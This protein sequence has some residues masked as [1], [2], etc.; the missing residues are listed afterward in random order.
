MLYL[1]KYPFY[2]DF[3]VSS[4]G[5][6]DCFFYRKNCRLW[7]H[8][9]RRKLRE[10]MILNKILGKLLKNSKEVYSLQTKNS[11]RTFLIWLSLISFL[12]KT[13]FLDAKQGSKPGGAN[14]IPR[15]P[16]R[17]TP[18]STNLNQHQKFQPPSGPPTSRKTPPPQS[19]K[20]PTPTTVSSRSGKVKFKFPSWNLFLLKVNIFRLENQLCDK[21]RVSHRPRLH[22]TVDRKLRI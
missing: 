15:T 16:I 6:T 1:S 8:D 20:S 21:V 17:K 9:W 22:E 2:N 7:I 19:R 4:Q 5:F 14:E 3:Y 13:Y 10:E 11:L 12:E 18:V